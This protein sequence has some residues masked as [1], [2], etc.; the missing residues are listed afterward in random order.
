[1]LSF[2]N[3]LSPLGEGRQHGLSQ[4]HWISEAKPRHGRETAK[5]DSAEQ[6]SGQL[7]LLLI[8][9]ESPLLGSEYVSCDLT[10][11]YIHS[12]PSLP[13]WGDFMSPAFGMSW[14]FHP[15]TFF[16]LDHLVSSNSTPLPLH[17]RSHCQGDSLCPVLLVFILRDKCIYCQW[18][19]SSHRVC[20]FTIF[21]I[22]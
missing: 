1:M 18:L 5:E 14:H 9:H 19:S 17:R 10:A 11:L 6:G 13:G 15:V 3:S 21:G 16:F 4:S 8:C 7:P 20:S 12:S 22:Y 2:S